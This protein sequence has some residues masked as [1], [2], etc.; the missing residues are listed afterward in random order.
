MAA[1][2]NHLELRRLIARGRVP[3]RLQMRVPVPV[4]RAISMQVW[5]RWELPRTA[6]NER[7]LDGCLKTKRAW[8]GAFTCDDSSGQGQRKEGM[9]CP[10]PTWNS[11]QV[12]PS[13]PPWA[14]WARETGRGMHVQSSRN[15]C[16]PHYPLCLAMGLYRG[17]YVCYVYKLGLV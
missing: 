4:A 2:V 14:A 3:G 17:D 12:I 1:P 7:S 5:L 11:T 13:S 9:N 8:M 16:P 15:A 6:D 10:Q